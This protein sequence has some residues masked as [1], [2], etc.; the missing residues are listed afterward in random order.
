MPARSLGNGGTTGSVIGDIVDNGV[1]VFNRSNALTYGGV[2]SGSGS[3]T[4]SG[5]GA[6]TLTGDNI[7]TGGTTIS[8]GTLFSFYGNGGG[9]RRGSV[10]GYRHRSTTG[11]A[12]SFRPQRCAVTFIAAWSSGTG[13][14]TQA[15]FGTLVL[16]GAN[17]YTGITTV[18][19]GMLVV[20]RQ[21]GQ[22]G[23]CQATANPGRAS[24]RSTAQSPSRMAA[25]WPPARAPAR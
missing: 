15:G 9:T 24:E 10:A 8:A 20:D 16:T 11:G 2:I 12:R 21:P 13:T 14:L 18:A 23:Q 19:G 22:R 5:A 3:V 4:K 6:L 17:T 25:R 7:Y 1:L